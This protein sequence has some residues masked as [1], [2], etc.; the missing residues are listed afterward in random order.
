MRY[1]FSKIHRVL[2]ELLYHY[3][4]LTVTT[5][6]FEIVLARIM[7]VPPPKKKYNFKRKKRSGLCVKRRSGYKEGGS[8][9]ISKSRKEK[10]ETRT[11]ARQKALTKKGLEQQLHTRNRDLVSERAAHRRTQ[12]QN[13]TLETKHKSLQKEHKKTLQEQSAAKSHCERQKRTSQS[14]PRASRLLG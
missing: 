9:R 3:C 2:P 13:Q 14:C 10:A 5:F 1:V 11:K 8:V 6:K 4:I 7:E 12:K